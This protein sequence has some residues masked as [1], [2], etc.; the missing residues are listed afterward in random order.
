MPPVARFLDCAE[1]DL[2]ISEIPELLAEYRRV[3]AGLREMGGFQ[4]A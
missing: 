2:K 4:D 3:V 1:G